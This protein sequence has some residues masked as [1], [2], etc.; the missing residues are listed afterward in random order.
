M[1]LKPFDL[2]ALMYSFSLHTKDAV[3]THSF[4]L[5]HVNFF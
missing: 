1:I 3:S 5:F 2:N 4:L